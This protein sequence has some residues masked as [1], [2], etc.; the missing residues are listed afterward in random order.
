MDG[1]QIW[2][3]DEGK[4]IEPALQQLIFDKFFQAKNQTLRKPEGS[5]LGLAICKKIIDMHG[6]SI[7][8]DSELNTGSK[9]IFT[10]PIN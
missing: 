8:V 6:G 5:G 4:G 9:F 10:L 1:L 7:W 2:V 3:Q